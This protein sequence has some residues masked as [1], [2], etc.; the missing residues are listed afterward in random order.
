MAKGKGPVRSGPDKFSG[1]RRR[2][3][4]EPVSR[5]IKTDLS[6]EEIRRLVQ[7]LRV[8]QVELEMQ[9]EELRRTQTELEIARANY[10]DLYNLAPVG[11]IVISERGTLL[12]ANLTAAC[13]LG[14]DR[15]ALVKKPFSRYI[16]KEDQDIFY[17]HRKQLFKT[18]EPQ[19]F[20]LRLVNQMG[21]PSWTQLDMTLGGEGESGAALVC[22]IALSDIR[23]RKLAEHA[24][25]L[26]I[27]ELEQALAKVKTLSG[28]LP[29]CAGCK[30][31]RDDQGYWSQ[32]EGFI[33]EHSDARFTH[34]M[35]PDC[36]NKYYPRQ[37]EGGEGS[38]G[39]EPPCQ[40]GG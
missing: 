22:R 23:E 39:G 10:F 5:D 1:L 37:K 25:T 33:Q 20:E 19:R 28:L 11:Y 7:E 2:A 30:R 38:A 6:P 31:I 34:S 16:F 26:L 35:C 36:M 24:R 17:L 27:A 40:E 15:G 14:A 32:V 9:N 4:K 13:L 21:N 3:K 29:I 8:H 12:E 18:R